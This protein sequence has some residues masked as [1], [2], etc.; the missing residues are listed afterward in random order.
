MLPSSL[1]AAASS[2]RRNSACAGRA[3]RSSGK[4]ESSWSSEAFRTRRWASTTCSQCSVF[5]PGSL[6]FAGVPWKQITRYLE[7]GTSSGSSI[8]SMLPTRRARALSGGQYSSRATRSR[9]SSAMMRE[10]DQCRRT[11]SQ[12][13]S[14]KSAVALVTSSGSAKFMSLPSCSR[15]RSSLA[16]IRFTVTFFAWSLG[17]DFTRY[18]GGVKSLG[19][20][21]SFCCSTTLA[22]SRTFC[23]C[24]TVL[25]R[26]RTTL[27]SSFCSFA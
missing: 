2:R 14:S 20:S 3:F 27:P 21:V 10:A 25:S 4:M 7:K 22:A 13:P 1:P 18:F 9:C 8:C 19:T 12:S 6:G 24:C 26:K 16:A 23:S 5:W 11:R 17:I 15:L